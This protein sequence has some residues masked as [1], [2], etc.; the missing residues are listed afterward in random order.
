MQE[1]GGIDFFF[2]MFKSS[3]IFWENSFRQ[4]N[5]RNDGRVVFSSVY[6][7]F[8]INTFCCFL[9]FITEGSSV[10]TQ[11]ESLPLLM[12]AVVEILLTKSADPIFFIELAL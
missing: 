5:T 10:G 12:K 6:Q 7:T 2:L 8:L 1:K 9:F 4:K 3:I 11:Q